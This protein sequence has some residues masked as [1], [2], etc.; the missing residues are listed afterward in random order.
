MKMW[1]AV[2]GLILAAFLMAPVAPAQ[3]ENGPIDPTALAA[4]PIQFI[5]AADVK[6]MIDDKATTFQLVDTQPA[7]AYEEGHVPGAV[8]YPWVSQIKPPV[9][10][11]RNKTLILYC[12]CTHDEDSI[13]MAK[14]LAEFGYYNVKILEGGW[15]KWVALKYPIDGT[16]TAAA[17]AS[18]P[19]AAPAEAP[20]AAAP[21]AAPATANGPLTSGR[22]VGAV[23]P[24]FRVIDVTGKYKGEE[25]CYVC[26]YG[27]APTIIGFFDG[28][29]DQAA[30]LIVKLNAVAQKGAPKNL[31]AFAV[32]VN[33][34]DSKAWLEKLAQDKGI[35]IP[36]VYLL[37]GTADLGVRL[38][39]INTQAK[40][41]F[42]VNDKRQVIVNMVNVDDNS[43]QQIADASTKMLGGD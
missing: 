4:P 12:P 8:N 24:S 17:A 20:A 10:L 25:T 16:N 34:P 35:Q 5:P 9:P 27:E 1:L 30:D 19:G 31:K 42:L 18:V 7:E 22:Q 28:P 11:P 36:L 21:A 6:K 26:E 23:T 32:M 43:F 14:K 39:K 3:D 41:T 37:K 29:S 2:A 15:Y 38:Y 13:D 40:N 33:G